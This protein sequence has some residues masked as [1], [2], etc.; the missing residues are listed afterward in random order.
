MGHYPHSVRP[1]TSECARAAS[2]SAVAAATAFGSCGDYVGGKAVA[3][4]TALQGAF[5]TVIFMPGYSELRFS[6]FGPCESLH[7][8][9]RSASRPRATSMRMSESIRMAFNAPSSAA[10]P[11]VARAD[12]HRDRKGRFGPSI[13]RRKPAWLAGDRQARTSISHE[14]PG[15]PVRRWRFPPA[16]SGCGAFPKAHRPCKVGFVSWCVVY[17]IDKGRSRI[18]DSPKNEVG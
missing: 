10:I 17:I 8:S 16:A 3:A 12:R 13:S 9:S 4:A 11:S 1:E 5:G 2:W 18:V 7:R 14:P 6:T 15:G